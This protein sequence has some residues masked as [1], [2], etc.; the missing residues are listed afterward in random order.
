MLER[1]Q[2]SGLHTTL[3]AM[4]TGGDTTANEKCF[5]DNQHC[6]CCATIVYINTHPVSADLRPGCHPSSQRNYR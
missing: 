4:A 1:Q 6:L 2:S 3:L 5:Q